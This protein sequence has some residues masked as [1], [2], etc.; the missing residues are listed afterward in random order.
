M[1]WSVEASYFMQSG[2]FDWAPVAWNFTRQAWASAAA[3]ESEIRTPAPL[4]R[5]TLTG[6]DWLTFHLEF[7]T[8]EKKPR[9]RYSTTYVRFAE[10]VVPAL[11]LAVQVTVWT[12]GVEVSTDPQLELATPDVASVAFGDA[13]T[14]VCPTVIGDGALSVGPSSGFVASRLKD[15]ETTG[16]SSLPS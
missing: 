8:G 2:P 3:S 12:P 11:S 7:G 16:A 10:P 9:I 13:V 1:N 15:V 5:A 4:A 6:T 14:P